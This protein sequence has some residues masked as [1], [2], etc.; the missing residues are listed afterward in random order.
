MIKIHENKKIQMNMLVMILLVLN[1]WLRNPKRN[2]FIYFS[3][4]CVQMELFGSHS[5]WKGSSTFAASGSTL[6]PSM[7]SICN[8]A[9]WKMGGTRDK[10][11]KF[12]NAGD[13]YLGRTLTGLDLL[14]SEFGV[15]PPYFDANNDNDKAK[16]DDFI[17]SS[18]LSAIPKNSTW[19]ENRRI[20]GADT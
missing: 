4:A 5:L 6:T 3:R 11:I 15:T 1:I 16:V 12:E 9:G 19:R 14:S 18:F 17:K 8:Q 13:Q 2:D 10:H 7:A 20:V